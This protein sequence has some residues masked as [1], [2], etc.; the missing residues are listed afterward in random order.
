MSYLDRLVRVSKSPATDYHNCIFHYPFQRDVAYGFFT[1]KAIS[2]M[3]LQIRTLEKELA[4]FERKYGTQSEVIYHT[5]GELPTRDELGKDYDTWS[6]TYE[7]WRNCAV[8][9]EGEFDEFRHKEIDL[10]QEKNKVIS[11]IDQQTENN[12]L[13]VERIH[14]EREQSGIEFLMSIAGM[15]DSEKTDTSESVETIVTDSILKKYS[16]S[17]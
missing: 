6:N 16:K 5:Q 14:E 9:Y 8:N 7:T 3:W 15:F 17:Q 13:L 2:D 11:E 10:R 1:S 4:Y 12:N